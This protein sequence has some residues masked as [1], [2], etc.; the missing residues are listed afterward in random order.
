MSVEQKIR[1]FLEGTT[2]AEAYPGFGSN[3]DAEAPMQGSSQKPQ[4]NNLDKGAGADAAMKAGKATSLAAGSGPMD[5]KNPTQGSSD[6]NP[7]HDD[8]GT[9][10]PGKVASSKMSKTTKHP[11]GKGAGQ[12]KTTTASVDP[13]TVVNQPN[14]KGNVYREDVEIE[15]G[16]DFITEDEFAALSPEEQAEYEMVEFEDELEE[17][18]KE[19]ECEDCEDEDED[20]EDDK[21]KKF[22]K[23]MKKE[24]VEQIYELSKKTLASY[25]SKAAANIGSIN[26]EHGYLE[27]SNEGKAKHKKMLMKATM[28][29]EKGIDN[30]VSKLTK[31]EVEQL[32]EL[33]KK[34]LGSY[35]KKAKGQIAGSDF[36]AGQEMGYRKTQGHDEDGEYD[37]PTVTA[38]ITKSHRRMDG[39][40]NA[41]SKLAKEE[42]DLSALFEGDEHLSEEF[43]TRAASLFEAVVTARVAELREEIENSASEAAAEIIFD[44]Q[45]EM[46]EKVDAYLNY[47][48][49]QWLE[50]NQVEVVNGLR[51]EVT[52]DFI[53]GLRNLFAENYIEVPEERYDV[54][55]EMQQQIEELQTALN[56]Q[57]DNTIAINEELITIKRESAI[58]YVCE[59]LAQTEIEKFKSLIEEVTFEDENSYIEK[60][61][62]I[63]G[64]YFPN[65]QPV[66]PVTESEDI[67]EEVE[68]SPS[69]Q[70][71]V[72][73]LS[74]TSFSK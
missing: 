43:K 72:E 42:V 18:K 20:E 12:A 15:E 49:E 51:N 57:I 6:A 28:K 73:A 27:G 3:R 53:N 63:K 13:S 5:K 38:N 8:L 35:I 2:V 4:V 59:D 21:K 46:V 47:V 11:V 68:V 25:A 10:M 22:M 54:L 16:D 14:S 39:V 33:S 24:E 29:R 52:E 40:K 65:S 60:L 67:S 56:E 48:V 62:V 30:A 23:N 36:S 17:E 41:A 19:E 50:Q 7:Q 1:E 58:S 64:N 74:K 71:Y 69:V 66:S 34:T 44:N 45:Q 31:E 9:D 26:R 55:G 61:S 37:S 70:K 32:Y